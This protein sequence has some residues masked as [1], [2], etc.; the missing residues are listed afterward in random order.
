M[1]QEN[2]K[3]LKAEA[4]RIAKAYELIVQE[5]MQ[6]TNV[7]NSLD[8]DQLNEQLKNIQNEIIKL[9]ESKM[10]LA[11]VGTMKAGKSTTI[12]AI[13]GKEVVP[14]R[15][16][17]MTT[18][19]TQIEHTKG[20]DVPELT[21]TKTEPIIKLCT[22]IHA[23]K[24]H[25]ENLKKLQQAKLSEQKQVDGFDMVDLDA[26]V[27]FIDDSVASYR[28]I[29]SVKYTGSHDIYSFLKTLNDLARYATL[30]GKEFPYEEYEN[31]RD[32]PVINVEFTSLKEF[33]QQDAKLVLLDTP[34]ANEA[35]ESKHLKRILKQQ[36]SKA[37]GV[38][39]VLDY[40]Q[41]KSEADHNLR[42]EVK[43]VVELKS[44]SHLYVMVNKFDQ[45]DSK[46]DGA[47]T[48]KEYISNDLM[49]GYVKSENVFPVSA[50]RA[51][52]ANRACDV[53]DKTGKLPEPKEEAWVN[54]FIEIA[55]GVSVFKYVTNPE[56][57]LEVAKDKWNESGFS[58]PLTKVIATTYQN[59]IFYILKSACNL[60]KLGAK[61]LSNS[62][63]TTLQ[64]LVTDLGV[65]NDTVK[66]LEKDIKTLEE[67]KSNTLHLVANTLDQLDRGVKDAT[68][69]ITKSIKIELEVFFKTGKTR[70]EEQ[71]KLD[72]QNQKL[73][74][75]NKDTILRNIARILGRIIPITFK[76]SD[77]Q[78][79]EEKF[80]EEGVIKYDNR[81]DAENLLNDINAYYSDL[82]KE[83]ET[84]TKEEIAVSFD[85]LFDEF[86]KETDEC[87]K[88]LKECQTR[89]SKDKFNLDI[90]MPRKRD[91]STNI[92][93]DI[94]MD[95]LIRDDKEP[96]TRYRR[97]S[98]MW[99][100]VCSWFNTDDWG[101]EGYIDKKDVYKIELEKIKKTYLDSWDNVTKNINNSITKDVRKP[102]E[103]DIDIYFS[104]VSDVIE[105]LRGN[106]IAVIQSHEIDKKSKEEVIDAVGKLKQIL[107]NL[108]QD[109]ENLQAQ[110]K[111]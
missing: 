44:E 73:E 42:D 7:A 19:P 36:L 49:K 28:N 95:S 111:P 16:R 59:A 32:L 4:I 106:F 60:V 91:L 2:I 108:V 80:I 62:Y 11:I 24:L 93:M 99:G 9:D 53:L 3:K 5:T 27:A 10:V 25:K 66:R 97:Q 17:P 100:T 8:K 22:E 21:F 75:K 65:L 63:N 6:N 23:T 37:S 98:G 85:Y 50:N 31:I 56:A 39:T 90:P 12:N 43:K 92:D 48:V 1:H 74:Q 35:G 58:E 77:T 84:L 51:Y 29:E 45:K 61:N 34:G 89:L 86:A 69:M 81:S 40:T 15:N 109:N 14:S 96:V 105:R 104:S 88:V 83:M 78:I 110:L 67:V 26:L 52:L 70:Q 57:R 13:I 64:A 103:K 38:I 82:V 41:L 47:E 72:E 76:R 71:Q 87:E 101:W 102:L 68:T 79:I 18:L 107:I 46:S 94:I 54:D 20:L 33:E 55:G 30:V